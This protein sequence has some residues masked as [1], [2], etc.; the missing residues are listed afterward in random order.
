MQVKLNY[1]DGQGMVEYGLIL[2]L[3]AIASVIALSSLGKNSVFKMFEQVM[4]IV[5]VLGR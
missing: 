1:E 5:E 4:K 2:I 3:V